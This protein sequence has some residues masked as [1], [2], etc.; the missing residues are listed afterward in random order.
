MPP[1]LAELFPRADHLVTEWMA[2]H[3]ANLVRIAL[4]IVFL[5]FGLLKFFPG[6]SP[7]EAL[8][9]RTVTTITVGRAPPG[10]SLPVLATWECAIGLG[11]L[12]GKALRFTLLLLALQM[13]G[14]LLPLVLFRDLTWVHFPYAPTLEGE[15]IIKNL[16]FVGAALVVG[17]TV[18]GGS[19]VADPRAASIAKGQPHP[20]P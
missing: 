12:T 18:R 10:L 16:V 15:F 7:A 20:I 14:T 13:A 9:T 8:A 5:W 17:A 11:L 6:L 4:G 2:R 19:L 3:G 1:R